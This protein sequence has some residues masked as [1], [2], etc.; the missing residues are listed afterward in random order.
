MTGQNL[1]RGEPGR[2]RND[3]ITSS[4]RKCTRREESE[5]SG[6]CVC[7]CVCACA[8][9]CVCEREIEC[10]GRERGKGWRNRES[11]RVGV[12]GGLD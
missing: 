5:T 1:R 6:V 9:V 12:E 2:G 10:G 4:A 11:R 8:C 7:A 3:F